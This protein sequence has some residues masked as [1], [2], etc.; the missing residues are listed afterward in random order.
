MHVSAAWMNAIADVVT[1]IVAPNSDYQ[2]C[3]EFATLTHIRN[4]MVRVYSLE[5]HFTYN[6]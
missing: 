3:K 4:Q 1:S 2:S 6:K 5:M